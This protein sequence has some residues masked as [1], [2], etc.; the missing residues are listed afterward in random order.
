MFSKS[1]RRPDGLEPQCR[2]CRHSYYSS[3]RSKTIRRVLR[4]QRA[5]R[6]ERRVYMR[7]YYRENISRWKEYGRTPERRDYMREY[8][9]AY[10]ER[11]AERMKESARA[12]FRAHPDRYR[13]YGAARRAREAAA[14]GRYTEQDVRRLYEKQCGA[15]FYCGDQ[16]GD[17]YTVDHKTPLARSELRPT[18]WPSNLCLACRP[19]NNGKKTKTAAEYVRHR[20][21]RGLH[22]TRA[23]LRTIG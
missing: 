12:L 4:Y 11:N 14:P 5:H 9:P 17:R 8:L 19:C 3:N 1:C 23:A 22:C 7:R 10:Y 15:C 2:Y 21:R 18:N 6:E 16:L 20:L 13:A